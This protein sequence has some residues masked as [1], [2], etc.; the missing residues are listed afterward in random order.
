MNLAQAIYLTDTGQ[1]AWHD[2]PC[3]MLSRE[4]LER[5]PTYAIAALS[6]SFTRTA[7]TTRRYVT[8]EQRQIR[9]GTLADR[10]LKGLRGA[11]RKLSFPDI[12]AKVECPP[13]RA[14]RE[15]LTELV[16]IGRLQA[17]GS[18]TH[19]IYWHPSMEHE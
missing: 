18:R 7:G 10:F 2:Q 5:H 8:P 12:C 4:L 9:Q 3:S 11:H 16:R 17:S 1:P 6:C 13:T 19:R 14:N 15:V